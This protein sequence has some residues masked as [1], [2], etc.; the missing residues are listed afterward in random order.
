MSGIQSHAIFQHH[1]RMFARFVYRI[2][3]FWRDFRF[4]QVFITRQVGVSA[5]A[6]KSFTR[7]NKCGTIERANTKLPKDSVTDYIMAIS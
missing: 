6:E 3:P 4:F 5:I 7:T 1:D 2:F